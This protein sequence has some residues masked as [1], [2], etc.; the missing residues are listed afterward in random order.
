MTGVHTYVPDVP[1]IALSDSEIVVIAQFTD[2][3]ALLLASTAAYTAETSIRDL[4]AA[5]ETTKT[6]SRVCSHPLA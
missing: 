4:V 6:Q 1:T 5:A 2:V 3:T